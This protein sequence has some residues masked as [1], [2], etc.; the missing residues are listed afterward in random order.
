MHS[1]SIPHVLREG[2]RCPELLVVPRRTVYDPGERLR[3]RLHGVVGAEEAAAEF[4]I[5][6]FLGSGFAGQVYRC[7]LLSMEGRAGVGI[8]GLEIGRLYAVKILRPAGAFSRWFRDLVYAVGFQAPFASEVHPIACRRGLL[9]QKLVRAAA[10]G[11]FGRDTAVKDVYAWFFDEEVGACG[12]VTEWIEGRTWRLEADDQLWRRRRWRLLRPEDTPSAEYV[13]KRQFMDRLTRMLYE[14][15][16]AEFA[17]Q[18]TWW[19]MK[20]QPNVL[21]RFDGGPGPADGLCAIDFR[22]GLA[23]LPFLPMSPADVWLILRG[24]CTRGALVQF[25]RCDVERLRRFVARNLGHDA[26]VQ[27]LLDEFCRADEATR[28]LQPDLTHQGMALLQDRALRRDVRCGLIAA[29]RVR[30][31]LSEQG[32]ERLRSSFPSFLVFLLLGMVPFF[33]RVLRRLWGN[34]VY[35]THVRLLLSSARYFRAASRARMCSILQNWVRAGRVAPERAAN[36]ADRPVRFW[37]ECLLLGWVPFPI[38][39]RWLAEPSVLMAALRDRFRFIYRFWRDAAFRRAYLLREIR[40]AEEEGMLMEEEKDQILACID[41]PYIS[42]YLMSLAVHFATLPVTQIVSIVTASVVAGWI[43]VSNG[44]SPEAWKS[45]SAWFATILFL[46]QITP[47]SPGSLCRGLYVV[48]LAVRERNLRD[49]LIALPVSFLKYFGYF[50]FPL[51]MAAAYPALSN[52]MA[53]RRVTAAARFVPVFGERGALFEHLVFDLTFNLPRTLIRVCRPHAGL[54]LSVWM[55]VGLVLW[56]V[57]WAVRHPPLTSR[58]GLNFTLI[59]LVL[60]VFPRLVF[61]PLLRR[62]SAGA[63]GGGAPESSAND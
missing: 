26:T 37:T 46:F 61:W 36:M 19:T 52:L 12:E 55:V 8:P 20:S 35:R 39:H 16:G 15:G 25:D 7:R 48:Y 44:W 14:M 62:R 60:F 45:A 57:V 30:G 1:G 42:K 33:G 5:E 31:Y 50:A 59:V 47:I 23:L 58:F 21:K 56:A 3:V 32:A 41:D 51:Q 10:A 24:L 43:L 34:P 18:Y 29:W 27:R 11:E 13:A 63:G 38:V 49:Y 54:L 28:R 53:A 2:T 22:A 9:W 17:R 4:G 6:S 40:A